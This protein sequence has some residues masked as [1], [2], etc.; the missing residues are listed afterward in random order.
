MVPR[1]T[2]P[3]LTRY[4][5]E[6]LLG[7]GT[8]GTVYLARDLSL[9]REVA[10]K[11]IRLS[12]PRIKDPAETR[13]RF[14]REVKLTA[15]LSHPNIIVV[16]DFGEEA[17]TLF[18][19]M[20]HVPGGTLAQRLAPG[21]VPFPIGER[22]LLATEL[23]EAIAHAH[24]KGILHRDLKPANILL[25][26]E[27]AAKITDFGIG[28]LLAGD[29]DLTGSGEMIGSPAYMSPE[30]MRG[31]RADTRSDIF[32]LGAV[33][34]HLLS[35]QRPFTADNL[36][37]LVAQV[38]TE[39]L[40]DIFALEPE[41]PAEIGPIL[42][43]CL[44]KEKEARYAS[45]ADLA[46]D[47]H[48]LVPPSTTTDGA[49]T[50]SGRRRRL[51]STYRS[52]R[53]ASSAV[54]TETLPVPAP[55]D[56]LEPTRAT[57]ERAAQDLPT[58]RSR[59]PERRA[60]HLPTIVGVSAVLLA[61]VGF[62]LA[63]RTD[64]AD[65]LLHRVRRR[66][67]TPV[68]APPTPTPEPEPT[69]AWTPAPTPIPTAVVLLGSGPPVSAASRTL[70]DGVLKALPRRE[71]LEVGAG[72]VL[73]VTPANARVLLDG[74]Q[75]G[76]AS[77]WDIRSGGAPL[78]FRKAGRHELRFTSV[79][80][81]DLI[82]EVTSGVAGVPSLVRLVEE[83]PEGLRSSRADAPANVPRPDLVTAGALR[84]DVQ[85]PD[86]VVS[87]DGRAMGPAT[88]WKDADLSLSSPGVHE[89]KL[90]AKGRESVVL[91]VVASPL[92]DPARATVTRTLEAR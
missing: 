11:V 81:R 50:S 17:E 23:A 58:V 68:P 86:A 80:R 24:G 91:R 55:P 79:G 21:T 74:R 78:A 52:P 20:E 51:S 43:R 36:T 26:A 88:R 75:A 32:G 5:I 3:N 69:P 29:V 8:G 47:L 83:L 61:A 2:Q 66:A 72:L 70:G 45:A 37:G 31:E 71:R 73:E 33:L 90:T 92:A 65:G 57:G 67:P 1:L 56:P 22:I 84:F 49:T 18:L 87:V 42:A 39:P 76:V 12:S 14:L 13:A 85:P 59:P 34:Y 82:V 4:R 89:V 54:G 16:Y 63:V 44:A 77:D 19:A 40:P 53:G 30:Q 10:L 7:E 35:G 46:A 6:R 62:Y 28:K 38:Q 48:A 27:G 60:G 25:T 9:E 64:D 41:L 15:R